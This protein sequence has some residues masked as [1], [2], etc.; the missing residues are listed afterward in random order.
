MS[1]SRFFREEYV[2]LDTYKSYATVTKAL[3]AKLVS[4]TPGLTIGEVVSDTTSEYKVYIYHPR[5]SRLRYQIWNSG[6]SMYLSVDVLRTN[7]TWYT[8]DISGVNLTYGNGSQACVRAWGI[9]D[10]WVWWQ[11]NPYSDYQLY[12]DFAYF[13]DASGTTEVPVIGGNASTSYG[14]YPYSF[15]ST[16]YT[17]DDKGGTYTTVYYSSDSSGVDAAKI[18]GASYVPYPRYIHATFRTRT[19]G[20]VNIRWGGSY[21][22]SALHNTQANTLVTQRPGSYASINGATVMSTGTL[23]LAT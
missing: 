19:R 20:F 10:W 8:G 15:E 13:T 11:I 5:S 16:K 18:A 6:N 7:G 4:I 12:G 1:T 14:N 17:Y 21:T 23:F 3:V 22:L 9:G 2:P